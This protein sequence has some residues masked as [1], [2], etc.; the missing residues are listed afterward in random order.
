[1]SRD[2]YIPKQKIKDKIKKLENNKEDF[3]FYCSSE[4]IRTTVKTHL[5][6]L[7]EEE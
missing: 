7:L 5:Q 1:M 2:D 4:D 6:E 3:H